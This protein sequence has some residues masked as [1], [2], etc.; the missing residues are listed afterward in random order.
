M[1]GDNTSKA[2]AETDR[3]MAYL[4]FMEERRRQAEIDYC[5]QLRDEEVNPETTSDC[6]DFEFDGPSESAGCE[7]DYRPWADSAMG[8]FVLGQLQSRRDQGLPPMSF[9][10]MMRRLDG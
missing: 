9:E 5:W 10:E 2:Y 3:W 7:D 4:W 1:N 8:L 6:W